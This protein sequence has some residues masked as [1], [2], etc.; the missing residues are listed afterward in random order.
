MLDLRF[1]PLLFT[2]LKEKLLWQTSF[3][4]KAIIVLILSKQLH[5]WEEMSVMGTLAFWENRMALGCLGSA[6]FVINFDF[7]FLNKS[8]QAKSHT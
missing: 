6:E 7:F 3:Q 2:V 5:V 4:N 1:L 8:K